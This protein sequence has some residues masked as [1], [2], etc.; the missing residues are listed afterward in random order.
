MSFSEDPSVKVVTRPTHLALAQDVR[1]TNGDTES[2]G[3]SFSP[4]TTE[5]STQEQAA[6]LAVAQESE[7]RDRERQQREQQEREP[8]D[9][10][11][12]L[13]ACYSRCQQCAPCLAWSIHA[14]G[15]SRAALP[16]ETW[17]SRKH[18]S[19]SE[20][21][22][23]YELLCVRRP[24]HLYGFASRKALDSYILSQQDV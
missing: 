7:E 16:C 2:D 22:A 10:E 5:P 18:Y 8:Q 24:D 19:S 15:V 9:I 6:Q 11:R 23:L 17:L 21:A 13:K 3:S 20:R 12:A 1:C 14:W 4:N